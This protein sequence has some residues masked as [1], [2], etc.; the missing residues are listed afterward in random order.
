MSSDERPSDS[1]T[2][3]R[4]PSLLIYGINYW[5]EVTGIAPYTTGIAEHLASKCWD[6]TVCTGMPHYPQWKVPR[7]FQRRLR[8]TERVNGVDVRRFRHFVPSS[9]SAVRRAMYEATFLAHSARLRDIRP[10]IVLG[11]VPSLGGGVQAVRAARKQS[12]PCVVLF[13]DLM[14]NAAAQS[15]IRGGNRV[16]RGTRGIER[17][18]TQRADAIGI[19]AE[20]F[21]S[22]IESLGVSPQNIHRV[23]NWAHVVPSERSREEVRSELGW[24]TDDIVVLH[25]GNMGLKQGLEH[26]VSAAV[27]SGKRDDQGRRLRFVFLGDGSQRKHIE[28]MAHGVGN[29]SFLDPVPESAFM[30]VLSAAD[31]LLVNERRSVTSMSLPSKLTSYFTAGRP[32]V[33]ASSAGGATAVEVEQSHAGIVVEPEQPEAL[34]QVLIR[35]A[36][37]DALC[38]SL[39]SAGAVYATT[40]VDATSSLDRIECVLRGA[41]RDDR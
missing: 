22:Y 34:V 13:Q 6:V 17:W 40:S 32:V 2:P 41:L 37:D 33:A 15:G 7:E 31:V 20:G 4:C 29:V 21:R 27:L 8:A 25:A 30:D 24:N 14:G 18:V 5:P 9:Q 16:A 23:P 26:V 35:L 39:G 12:V 1:D 38:Q 19:V 10:D 36:D 11:I 28:Q 3:A